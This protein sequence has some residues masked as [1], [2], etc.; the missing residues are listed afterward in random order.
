MT[1][2]RFG[3]LFAADERHLLEEVLDFHRDA[4]IRKTQG[5]D[6]VALRRSPVDS[7]VNLMGLVFHLTRT[8]QW[9]FEGCFCGLPFDGDPPREHQ[10]PEGASYGQVVD[11]YQQPCARSRDLV[12]DADLCSVA[13]NAF[14]KPTLRWILVHMIEETARHNGHAD[15]LRELIDGQTGE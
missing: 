5:L 14:M 10:A 2:D 8:E 7:G 15:I 6:D 13:R 12:K 11:A 1:V 4:L 9:W 3:P